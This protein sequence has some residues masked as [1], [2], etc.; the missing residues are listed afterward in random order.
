MG[1]MVPGL[2]RPRF[3]AIPD[4]GP[5]DVFVVGARGALEATI[6]PGALRVLVPP[7]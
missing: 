7:A 6:R 3:P 4:D 5:L 1:D 2:V